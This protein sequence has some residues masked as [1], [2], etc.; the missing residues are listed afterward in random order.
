MS[1]SDALRHNPTHAGL[2]N[3]G[4]VVLPNVFP[5]TPT[6]QTDRLHDI[7]RGSVPTPE[8]LER[9]GDSVLG[10]LR[11]AVPT[12]NTPAYIDPA[13]PLKAKEAIHTGSRNSEVIELFVDKVFR[14][15]RM[16]HQ[17]TTRIFAGPSYQFGRIQV[18]KEQGPIIGSVPVESALAFSGRALSG[19][20]EREVGGVHFPSSRINGWVMLGQAAPQDTA[21][22][23][24]IEQHGE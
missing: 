18:P 7:F 15:D 14:V 5:S 3:D 8:E 13:M 20:E 12:E 2:F 11:V 4:G 21:E 9:H 19:T 23:E 24:A 22:L 16:L 6:M 10:W 1:M 17:V